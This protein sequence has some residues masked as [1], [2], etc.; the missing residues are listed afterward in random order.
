MKIFILVLAARSPSAQYDTRGKGYDEWQE[1]Q[2]RPLT[3]QP[4][5]DPTVSQLWL[6]PT[7]LSA[8]LWILIASNIGVHLYRELVIRSRGRRIVVHKHV[9]AIPKAT[10]RQGDDDALRMVTRVGAEQL[11]GH[12]ACGSGAA[13]SSGRWRRSTGA[14]RS[15]AWFR[16]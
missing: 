7:I 1:G 6:A 16:W 12:A 8:G 3:L 13:S 2:L 14:R 4:G 9:Q 10:V 15:A 11:P 5:A